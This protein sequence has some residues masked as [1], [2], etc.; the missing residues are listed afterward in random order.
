MEF[1]KDWKFWGFI[2]AIAGFLFSVVNFYIS[3]AVTTKITQNDLKH[4]TQDV[5]NL[6]AENKDYK[7][8]LK[9][10]LNKIFRRLGK[11]DRNTAKRDALC[12]ERHNKKQR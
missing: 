11:I 12:E 9:D 1:W 3:K 6:K 10:E 7:K 8:E 4:L 5:E 2:I